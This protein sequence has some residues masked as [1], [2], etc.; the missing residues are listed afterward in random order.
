MFGHFID[1][2]GI[3]QCPNLKS[4]LKKMSIPH[5]QTKLESVESAVKKWRREGG[6]DEGSSASK[7]ALEKVIKDVLHS[8]CSA[9]Q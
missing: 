5:L 2:G 7:F 1:Y 8:I 4:L 3:L 6:M 9:R